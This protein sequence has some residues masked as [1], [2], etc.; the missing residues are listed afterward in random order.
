LCDVEPDV[1]LMGDPRTTATFLGKLS[2]LLSL[3][4]DSMKTS[5]FVGSSQYTWVDSVVAKYAHF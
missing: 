2:L 4:V 3:S 1:D 5:E